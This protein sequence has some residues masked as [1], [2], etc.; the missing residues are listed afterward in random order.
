[1]KT[2]VGSSFRSLYRNSGLFFHIELYFLSR[3][4]YQTLVETLVSR[5]PCLSQCV[6][7]CLQIIILPARLPQASR[8]FRKFY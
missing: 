7:R 4:P 5:D 2:T 3:D 6:Q 1:M 8:T